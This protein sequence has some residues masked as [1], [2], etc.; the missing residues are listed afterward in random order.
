MTQILDSI[1]PNI[2][3]IQ[4]HAALVRLQSMLADLEQR[5]READVDSA[6]LDDLGAARILLQTTFRA[7]L[8]GANA[9]VC[10]TEAAEIYPRSAEGGIGRERIGARRFGKEPTPMAVHALGTLR[11]AANACTQWDRERGITC[12]LGKV[13]T[14]YVTAA[15]EEV[16]GPPDR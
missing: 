13:L 12:G 10:S 8:H 16:F 5:L 11:V 14:E 1:A 15:R 3:P 4:S 9:G 7:P 2:P 6:V